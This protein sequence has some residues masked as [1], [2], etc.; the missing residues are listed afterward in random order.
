MCLMI[1]PFYLMI[2][3]ICLKIW[4]N[5]FDYLR[6]SFYKLGQYFCHLVTLLTINE[7]FILIGRSDRSMFRLK[8]DL[9]CCTRKLEEKKIFFISFFLLFLLQFL[10]H[11]SCSSIFNLHHSLINRFK[12]EVGAFVPLDSSVAAF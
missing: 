9:N 1:W 12:R 6:D 10:S 2:W 3:A 7:W 4:A 11:L 8:G 5:S